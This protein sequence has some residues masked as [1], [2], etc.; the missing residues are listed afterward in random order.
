MEQSAHQLESTTILIAAHSF[1]T[2][3]VSF[4]A[5]SMDEETRTELLNRYYKEGELACEYEWLQ[6]VVVPRSA[7]HHSGPPELDPGPLS[8]GRGTAR[9]RQRQ[10]HVCH[11]TLAPLPGLQVREKGNK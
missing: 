2:V 8:L 7:C 4:S 11:W 9:P 5:S 3:V 6:P 1:L 10:C